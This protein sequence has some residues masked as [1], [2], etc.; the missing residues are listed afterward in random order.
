MD[1]GGIY[2]DWELSPP[3]FPP[4]AGIGKQDFEDILACSTYT[5]VYLQAIESVDLRL[6]PEI[7]PKPSIRINGASNS[8]FEVIDDYV[9]SLLSNNL[10]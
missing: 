9:S 10:E 1:L 6:H 5:N 4:L 7:A 2:D 3:S 8:S